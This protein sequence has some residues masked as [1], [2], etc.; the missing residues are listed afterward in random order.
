MMHLIIFP[1]HPVLCCIVAALFLQPAFNGLKRPVQI[2]VPDADRRQRFYERRPV[3]GRFNPPVQD[4]KNA[5]VMARP[6]KPAKPLFEPEHGF[7]QRISGKRIFPFCPE[8]IGLC[9]YNRLIRGQKREA[10]HH[11]AGKVIARDVNPF[12]KTA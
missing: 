5:A 10:G 9:F 2:Q 4:K 7:G 6:D 1:V 12:P 11:E 8:I 3:C